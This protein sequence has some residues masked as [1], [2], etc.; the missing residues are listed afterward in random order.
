ML[1]VDKGLELCE[2]LVKRHRREGLAEGLDFKVRHAVIEVNAVKTPTKN[3]QL[4]I[5]DGLH[6]IGGQIHSAD[7]G[8]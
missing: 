7:K 1:A 4:H 5:A 8:M 2:A 3:I 6:H